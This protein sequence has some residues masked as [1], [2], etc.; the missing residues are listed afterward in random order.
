M[1]YSNSNTRSSRLTE[2]RLN[3]S[4]RRIGK[5]RERE[6]DTT[7]LGAT[8]RKECHSGLGLVFFAT[9]CSRCSSHFFHNKPTCGPSSRLVK[10]PI[11]YGGG[12][13]YGGWSAFPSYGYDYATQY[14]IRW[15]D[16]GYSYFLEY[17][18]SRLLLARA[19]AA[20]FMQRLDL[21]Y[22]CCDEAS[23]SLTED[24]SDE[25]VTTPQLSNSLAEVASMLGMVGRYGLTGGL[26]SSTTFTLGSTISVR[27]WCTHVVQHY[28]LDDT[29]ASGLAE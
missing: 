4:Q 14:N 10:T 23:K 1:V 20:E 13:S 27:L 7:I 24:V 26:E 12:S 19:T 2:A 22:L 29:G 9:E 18:F 17:E 16:E 8:I 25:L 6:K 3:G 11:L 15:K 5:R 28:P 21:V